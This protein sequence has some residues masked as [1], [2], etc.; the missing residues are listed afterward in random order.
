EVTKLAQSLNFDVTTDFG[1]LEDVIQRKIDTNRAKVRV[2]SDLSG[3]GIAEIQAEQRVE[4][5]QADDILRQFEVDMGLKT[6]ETA[7][8]QAREKSLG[9]AQGESTP[10]QK[11]AALKEVEKQIG[12]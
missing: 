10:D 3:Q 6:P 7:G 5:Q 1:Q 9:S 2:A 11:E 8:I 4:K 12:S